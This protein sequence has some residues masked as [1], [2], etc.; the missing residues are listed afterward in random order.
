MPASK[1]VLC[2]PVQS[3]YELIV[4]LIVDP[5]WRAS[6]NDFQHSRSQS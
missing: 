6:S 1:M 5:L 3:S 4:N 2:D